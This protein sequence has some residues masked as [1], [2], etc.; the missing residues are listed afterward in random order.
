M[1]NALADRD[2][3]DF[4]LLPNIGKD[5]ADSVKGSRIIWTGPVRT[6]PGMPSLDAAPREENPSFD[7]GRSRLRYS[8]GSM[9]IA[10]QLPSNETNLVA[11]R[12]K[13]YLGLG[14]ALAALLVHSSL[15]LGPPGRNPG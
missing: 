1:E 15:E 12:S 4:L 9:T 10:P 11:H 5:R 8:Q 3:C 2:A 14:L 13:D 7:G 6:V